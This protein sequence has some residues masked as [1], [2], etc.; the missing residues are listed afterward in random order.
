M[1]IVVNNRS[2]DSATLTSQLLRGMGMP[3]LRKQRN[4]C[5]RKLR[6]WDRDVPAR[7]RHPLRGIA[8]TRFDSAG[9]NMSLN[10]TMDS[11]L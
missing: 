8:T 1:D 4:I 11:H 10:E 3:W 5:E 2:R 9:I 7:I 6:P